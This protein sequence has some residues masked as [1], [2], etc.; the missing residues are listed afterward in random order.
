MRDREGF[1]SLI[2][3]VYGHGCS[4]AHAQVADIL[5][6][7]LVVHYL[8]ALDLF[9]MS[10][11]CMTCACVRVCGCV[12]ACLCVHEPVCV[13]VRAHVRERVRMH[14]SSLNLFLFFSK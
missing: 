14:E 9:G 6:S 2:S 8:S 11:L 10:C 3:I 5:C 1:V 13:H 7:V 12:L 4:T